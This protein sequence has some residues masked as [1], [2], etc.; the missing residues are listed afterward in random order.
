MNSTQRQ[1]QINDQGSM[2]VTIVP[3]KDAIDEDRDEERPEKCRQSRNADHDPATFRHVFEGWSVWIEP[4]LPVQETQAELIR[5]C[6]GAPRGVHPFTPHITLLYNIP[7]LSS[8]D[9]LDMLHACQERLLAQ[10][11]ARK[12][13]RIRAS[14]VDQ[15]RPVNENDIERS[16]TN[17]ESCPEEVQAPKRFLRHQSDENAIG[18]A[19]NKQIRVD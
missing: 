17:D 18:D 4:D 6:G 11:R 10:E 8:G 15:N 9:P 1:Q 12:E 5:A 3:A 2:K 14:G 16:W 7:A 19:V 13:A